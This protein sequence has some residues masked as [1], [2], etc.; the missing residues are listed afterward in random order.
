MELRKAIN[1]RKS[2]RGF[3]PDP[4]SRETLREVLQLATRAVSSVNGQPWELA[5]VTGDTLDAIRAEN[6]DCLRSGVPQDVPDVPIEGIYRDRRIALAKQLFI[7]MDIA[8]EDRDRRSWWL[9]R[10]FRFFD[11]PAAILL[12]MDSALDEATF[13]L[14]M[15]CLAQNICLAAME[16][17]LGTCVADQAI[18]Y[19]RG[20]REY[21]NIPVGK[22]FVSGIAIGYPDWDFP[23][24]NV[25]SARENIDD[26]VAW[27]GFESAGKE[28][29]W[30]K[31]IYEN[32]VSLT[33]R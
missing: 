15:G 26:V 17:G 13:R 33:Q 11:A 2:I 27:Y 29:T 23:A 6:I 1:E 7:A 8:R 24:N 14:D 21:L 30:I 12:L 28:G 32:S 20:L 31:Q 16:F 5:V 9:E 4:V 18:I 3:K 22:R 10:G 19:Q 25:V